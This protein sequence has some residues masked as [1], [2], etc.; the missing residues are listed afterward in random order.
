MSDKKGVVTVGE[1]NAMEAINDQKKNIERMKLEQRQK[2]DIE[3]RKLADL[4]KQHGTFRSWFN[5]LRYLGLGGKSRRNSRRGKKFN[6]T[7]K[8][9]RK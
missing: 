5:P 7:R 8:S 6:R 2:L 1:K 4:K 9:N 3:Y